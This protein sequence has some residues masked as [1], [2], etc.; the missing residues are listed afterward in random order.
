MFFHQ[1]IQ[2]ILPNDRVL[3]IGPGGSPHPRSDV[4]L[5]MKF[6]DKDEEILQRSSSPILKTD[7]PVIYYDGGKFP[8]SDQEFDYIICSHVLEHVADTQ[9]FINELQRVAN[10]G[11]LEYP[12]I[13]YEYLYNMP[14]HLNFLLQKDGKIYCIKK[15]DTLLNSFQPVHDFFGETLRLRYTSM[16]KDFKTL[17][18]QGFEWFNTIDFQETKSLTDV[19]FDVEKLH[20]KPKKKKK[21]GLG[22]LIQKISGR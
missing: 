4:F 19:T 5:E 3:E 12:T 16:I 22:R 18:F 14:T 7:K 17:F 15:S 10:K 1:K 21:R 9:F 6:A 13:Y 20:L 8:F 11:Y 2:N